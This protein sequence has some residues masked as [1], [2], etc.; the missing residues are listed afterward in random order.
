MRSEMTR[1]GRTRLYDLSLMPPSP[2]YILS[3]SPTPSSS[4]KLRARLPSIQEMFTCSTLCIASVSISVFPPETCACSEKCNGSWAKESEG[5]RQRQN[6]G[7]KRTR[8]VG[9]DRL[10]MLRVDAFKMEGAKDRQVSEV[11]LRTLFWND[12]IVSALYVSTLWPSFVSLVSFLSSRAR[13]P[14]SQDCRHQGSTS[15]L[16]PRPPYASEL[17]PD[18]TSMRH[19]RGLEKRVFM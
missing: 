8:G 17:C 6:G 1:N 14:A 12:E 10:D 19:L 3:P 18:S 7:W 2:Q 16:S 11:R 13:D 5:K 9:L 15:R 4:P